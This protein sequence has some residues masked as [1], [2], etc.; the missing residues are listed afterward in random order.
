MINKI[1]VKQWCYLR[2][3]AIFSLAAL[4]IF[5]LNRNH[6]FAQNNIVADDTLGNDRSRI[7]PFNGDN[8]IDTIRGGA[9]RGSNLFHSFQ[10]FN[11]GSE[12]GAYF[13]SPNAEIQN[14]LA[15]VTG[16]NP[17]EILGILGTRVFDGNALTSSNANLFLINPKGIVFG[18][19]AR[20]DV[21]GSFVATTADGIRFGEQGFF[22]ATQPEQSSLLSVS[23][24]ALFFEQVRSQPGNIV[25]RGNLAVGK[26]FTVAADNL[27]LQGQLLAGGDLNLQAA[28]TVKVRDG[29]ENP[30]IAAAKGELLLQ[31]NQNVDI[32]ALSH[33]DSGLFSGGDMV[34]R[35]ANQVGGD[36][37]YWS[38]GN[39]RIEQL[40][41]SL[42][43]LFSPYDPVIR[44]LGDVSFNNYLGAS[45]HILA[46]GSVNVP[47]SIFINNSETGTSGENFIAE[48]VTLSNGTILP[49]DGS[50]KPTLDIRAGIDSTQVGVSKI[51][52]NN[53]PNNLFFSQFVELSD[54]TF[55]LPENPV[56]S[57]TATSADIKIGTVGMLTDNAANG[58]VF[59]TNQYKPNTA[60][61]GGNIEV[62]TIRTD[63]RNGQFS[64]NAGSVVLDSRSDITVNGLINS[65]SRSG[66]SGVLLLIAAKDIILKPD[67][68]SVFGSSLDTSSDIGNGG[69]MTLNAGENILISDSFL[70]S[71]VSGFLLTENGYL[72][73]S[74]NG[75]DI[76]INA[77]KKI[78]IDDTKIS[79]S[80]NKDNGGDV[81]LNAVEDIKIENDSSIRVV[82]A[83]EGNIKIKGRDIDI[84]SSTLAVGINPLFTEDGNKA[85]NIEI[86][87][88]G[89]VKI[90]NSQVSNKLQNNSSNT[91]KMNAGD[92]IIRANLLDLLNG[93]V[94]DVSTNKQGNAGN[95]NIE[96]RDSV[97]I[98]GLSRTFLTLNPE[99]NRPVAGRIGGNTELNP[100][101]AFG[102][103][104]IE[105]SAFE[106]ISLEREEI[107]LS[108]I[109]SF[110]D[111]EITG[112]AGNI[113]IKAGSLSLTN[114]GRITANNFG[115]GN[116]GNIT[117]DIRDAVNLS[118][119]DT[120]NIFE[121]GKTTTFLINSAILSQV[122]QEAE[123][124]PGYINI[125]A[126]SL[127]MTDLAEISTSI[128]GK[129]KEDL[130]EIPRNTFDKTNPGNIFIKVKDNIS[131]TDQS[132]IRSVVEAGGAG[133]GGDIDIQTASLNINNGA[134]VATGIFQRQGKLP[135]GKGKGGNIQV[136]A[137]EE[138]N[139][140]GVSSVKLPLSAS[141]PL[142][143]SN[144]LQTEGISSGLLTIT[145]VGALGTAG[146]IIVDTK[147]FQI[148]D[149]GVVNAKTENTG[150]GGNITITTNIFEAQNGG[151][152]LTTAFDSGKAGN[153][154][155]NATDRIN[156]TGSDSTQPDRFERLGGNIVAN[157]VPFSGLFANTGDES[158]TNGGSINLETA[159]LNLGDGAKISAQSQGMGNAGNITIKASEILSSTD[160]TITTE[161]T[162][163]SGG[164]I[165][166]E[167][168]D[169]RLF[170]DSDITTLVDIGE[171]DGGN[172]TLT[173][174]TIIALE[175][176]DI[177]SFSADGKGGDINFNTAAFLSNPLYQP[178]PPIR[179]RQALNQ[180][181]TN[182]Q[183]DVN[184][185][186][187][188]S[189]TIA[190]VPDITFIQ[191][192][193]VE[194]PENQIDTNILVAN[195]CIVRSNSQNGTFFIT[196]SGGL[197]QNPTDAPLSPFSTGEV[198]SI[199]ITSN[200]LLT[201][202]TQRP[203]KIGD[204]IIEP[205]GVYKL[206][207]GQIVLSRECSK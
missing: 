73:G 5:G 92:I 47:G 25:N 17:S 156:L 6:A 71:G 106:N 114:G 56:S 115:T 201:S 19:N 88:F 196:G 189:G 187:T 161:T 84:L 155:I 131:L 129:G 72:S 178:T 7:V 138:V 153:I 206:P 79:S 55:A 158:T 49:I 141:N 59:L 132:T 90:E 105:E 128:F 107:Q 159:N 102:I 16:R 8:T 186:G 123:G 89:N 183:V 34:L 77:L 151:Q 11:I 109:R 66:N 33:P 22:S 91:Q 179:D 9:I 74:G 142:D 184:A 85:G 150:D 169:I 26:D 98:D 15:R 2:L 124:N 200:K 192:S 170:D 110:V 146:N 182:E 194:L 13:Y 108:G 126:G 199:P 207:N 163:S 50:L 64:G 95:V 86:N 18:E 145:E 135:G 38:G 173:A 81:N 195:S 148:S 137:S 100:P 24:G 10:E 140:S 116:A 61:S 167:A 29:F 39:F 23:P 68:S 35:S 63:D 51:P 36:G 87:S 164:N 166:I 168:G 149:G 97:T 190:G 53:F 197:P 21:G 136:N 31:G 20:L 75:G 27:D 58:T 130:T 133:N 28:D 160:G 117:L 42:G 157:D 40:D 176:S 54:F 152:V 188:V 127:S 57:N 96:V 180:L 118:G 44:S 191:N 104:S 12:N 181:N 204:P 205:S 14:I 69:D 174:N 198:Q 52:A 193:L 202:A 139:I 65:S 45:L 165:Q 122:E 134:Q 101:I 147:T 76:A 70:T 185:S 4:Q 41:G 60:L 120:S 43:D 93:G 111:K 125:D 144:L 32:F 62:G 46:G 1:S 171:G 99:I 113:H 203:W 37:K 177:L 154:T 162:Q 83:K 67:N 82:S 172:I 30:F 103:I 175:D 143:K 80:S 112:H 119:T 94:L 78:I 3:L 121:P 48:S